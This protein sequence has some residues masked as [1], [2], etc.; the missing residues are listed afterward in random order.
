[1]RETEV[2]GEEERRGEDIGGEEKKEA[3]RRTKTRTPHSD[4]G[5]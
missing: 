5:K 4:A 2:G 1:M 3:G